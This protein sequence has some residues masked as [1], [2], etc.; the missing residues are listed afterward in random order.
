MIDVN[1]IHEIGLDFCECETAQIR[2]KQLLR[3]RWYPATTTDPQTAATFSVLRLYHLLSFESKVSAYEFYHS[4]ARCSDNTGLMAIRVH[5]ISV[6]LWFFLKCLFQDRYAPFMCMVHEWRHLRQLQQ[7]GRGHD[8]SGVIATQAGKLAVI[9]PACSQPGRNLPEGWE[10]AEPNLKW[11]AQ[12][13]QWNISERLTV[14]S[15]W[16]YALFIAID[17]N[18]CLK[19]KA[20]SSDWV[21]PG[22]NTGWAYFVDEREYKSYLN[23]RVTEWQ[24][25]SCYISRI[26]NSLLI[27]CSAALVSAIMPSIWLTQ[28]LHVV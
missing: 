25:V 4:L 14:Y 13:M 28:N 19:R 5:K 26:Q 1:G 2:Y 12:I 15:R 23:D 24:E 11:A 27:S 21:D 9:C 18:F 3:A 6:Y 22:L 17:T 10:S 20:V 16:R 7:A 8:P